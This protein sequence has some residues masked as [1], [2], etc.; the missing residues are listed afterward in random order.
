MRPLAVVDMTPGLEGAVALFE[1]PPDPLADHLGLERAMEALILSLGLRMMRPAMADPD[2][3]P[4]QPSLKGG[5]R[6]GL[7]AV[8]GRAPGCAVV[9][10]HALGQAVAPEHRLHRANDRLQPL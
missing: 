6:T 1:I 5:E 10:Q 4:H 3:Q 8:P 7:A 9:G 2:A